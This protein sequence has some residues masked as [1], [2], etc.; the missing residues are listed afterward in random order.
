MYNANKHIC[1]LLQWASD[2]FEVN[3]VKQ[4]SECLKKQDKKYSKRMR[5]QN[6]FTFNM[7]YK[8]WSHWVQQI[9]VT[10]WIFPN[11]CHMI[12]KFDCINEHT[13]GSR[14]LNRSTE[15]K[16]KN[17]CSRAFHWKTY[18]IL[19]LKDQVASVLKLVE[20]HST[21]EAVYEAVGSNPPYKTPQ[22]LRYPQQTAFAV[23]VTVLNQPCRGQ[24]H[25]SLEPVCFWSPESSWLKY[26][27]RSE[28]DLPMRGGAGGKGN[29]NHSPER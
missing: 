8:S 27:A 24:M 29:R 28:L 25:Q 16:E 3:V 9:I 22:S 7:N 12:N 5:T 23:A 14:G 2:L 19:S 18:F 4:N 1:N 13:D 21:A 10:G 6:T 11:D 26:R 17:D 15:S 20:R